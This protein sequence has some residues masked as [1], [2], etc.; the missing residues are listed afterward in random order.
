MAGNTDL[1]MYLLEKGAPSQ[2]IERLMSKMSSS[3]GSS[4]L[5]S[6]TRPGMQGNTQ[7]LKTQKPQSTMFQRPGGP[8]RR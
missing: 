7:S 2:V 8:P 6:A 4:P 3:Q 5:M 1:M